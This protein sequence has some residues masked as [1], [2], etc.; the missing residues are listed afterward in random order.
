MLLSG[1]AAALGEDNMRTIAFAAFALLS[2]SACGA[3]MKDKQAGEAEVARFHGLFDSDQGGAIYDNAG[4]EL[5]AAASKDDFGKMIATSHQKLGNVRTSNQT[6]W[7]VNYGDSGNVVVL[8][9]T[10][11]FALA[12]GEEEFVYRVDAGKP[13]L[14]GY[15]VTSPA[16]RT[17]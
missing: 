4:A 7:K 6:G 15:H 2:L 12:R 14:I 16:L 3:M 11:D 10:T 17:R 1:N 5:K 13:K 9:Y 8:N